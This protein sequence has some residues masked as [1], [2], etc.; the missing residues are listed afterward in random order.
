MFN[1][2]LTKVEKELLEK[3]IYL[4]MQ[5]PDKNLANVFKSIA[6]KLKTSD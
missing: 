6:I 3:V 4:E 2:K 5:Y 1:L